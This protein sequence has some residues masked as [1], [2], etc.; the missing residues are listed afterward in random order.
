MENTVTDGSPK[1]KEINLL[2]HG[3]EKCHER[4]IQGLDETGP[5][6]SALIIADHDAKP[7][8]YQYQAERGCA[9]DWEY[10]Q[11]G[12]EVW[13]IRV[14]KSNRAEQPQRSSL[15][16]LDVREMPPPQRH[17][18]IFEKFDG[19]RSGGGF[20]LVNDHDPKPLYYQFAAEHE[21]KFSWEYL[22]KGP[23]VW[24]VAIGKGGLSN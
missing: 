7:V 21:G 5:G 18:T 9:L 15:V 2:E 20:I 8:L 3:H 16:E 23:L 24:R 13:K 17:K 10:E 4:V 14:I 1:E 12:P 11:E 6:D 22:E 19:L